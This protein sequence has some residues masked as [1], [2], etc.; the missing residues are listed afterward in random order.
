MPRPGS[1]RPVGSSCGPGRPRAAGVCSTLPGKRPAS[2]CPGAWQRGSRRPLRPPGCRGV[3][4]T[5]VG[6]AAR[7]SGL[8]PRPPRSRVSPPPGERRPLQLGWTNAS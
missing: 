5:C 1:R 3:R 8:A 2:G 7:S 6:H 4:G